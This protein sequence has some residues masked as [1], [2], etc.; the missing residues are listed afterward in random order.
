MVVVILVLF[1]SSVLQASTTP[2]YIVHPFPCH[3]GAPCLTLQD[4]ANDMAEYINSSA[5]FLFL[6]G[7]HYLNTELEL[8]F[9]KN[10]TFRGGGR[11]ATE[12]V[13]SPTAT[14]SVANSSNIII[15]S[16][17]II[18][19]GKDN[20]TLNSA[21]LSLQSTNFV[22]MHNIMFVQDN[23]DKGRSRALQFTNSSAE[24]INCSFANGHIKNG[25]AISAHSSHLTFSGK[26]L[27]QQ[28]TADF[29]G[30][31]IYANKTALIFNGDA[32]FSKNIA[33]SDYYP[34]NYNIGGGAIF[35]WQSTITF[36]GNSVFADNAPVHFFDYVLIGAAILAAEG[37]N[38]TI[39]G[40]STFYN[41]SGYTGGAIFLVNSECSILSPVSFRNN[42]ATM[43]SGGAIFVYASKLYFNNSTS[44]M[45]NQAKER[46]GGIYVENSIFR[47]NG[48]LFFI[49]NSVID[50]GGGAIYLYNSTVVLSGATTFAMNQGR[51][52]GAL[53]VNSNSRLVFKTGE[54]HFFDNKAEKG[55][56]IYFVDTSSTYA[57]QCQKITVE[58]IIC[59]FEISME[60]SHFENIQL[61]F[62]DNYADSGAAVYGGALDICKV[63]I[64]ENITNLRGYDVIS[65]I[66][67]FNHL[68]GES[69]Y[70]SSR[71]LKLCK[72]DK[73]ELLNCSSSNQ[74]LNVTVLPGRTFKLSVIPVGQFNMPSSSTVVTIFDASDGST[75]RTLSNNLTNTCRDVEYQLFTSLKYKSI[76]IY[77]KGCNSLNAS[78]MV[79]LNVGDCPP[80]FQLLDNTCKCEERLSNL[81][82]TD[83]ICD[84]ETGLIKRPGN[85][86][87]RPV[88]ENDTYE[89][90]QWSSGCQSV[91][92]KTSD[93]DNPIWLNFSNFVDEQCR[94]NHTGTLCGSCKASH[95]LVLS[96]MD[97]DLCDNKSLSLIL[98]FALA[99][100]ALIVVI[101]LL[102]LT[103]AKG[104]THG[105]ILYCNVVSICRDIIFPQ[106]EA[107]LSP[108]SIFIAWMN[109]DLGIPTCFFNGLD[110]Y[111]YA[112][113]QF[114]FPFYL[115]LLIALIIVTSK[116]S[117][118]IG[119]LFG[120]NPIAV[121]ATVILLSFTKLLQSSERSLSYDMLLNPDGT[122]TRVWRM[123]PSVDYLQGKHIILATFAILVIIILI[124]P[125]IFLL[126]FG[127]HLQKYSGR[128]GFRWFNNFKPLLDAYYAPYTKH[129]RYWT[130]FLLLLRS[131]LF[132][133]FTVTILNNTNATLVTAVSLFL[134]VVVIGWMTGRVYQTVY[135]E[136]LEASFILNICILAVA[137][138]HIRQVGKDQLIVSYT[139]VGIAFTQFVGIIIFHVIFRI[140]DHKFVV[141]IRSQLS[142]IY[143]KVFPP[144]KMKVPSK[145]ENSSLEDM[146]P[147]PIR[148]PLLEDAT[149]V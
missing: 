3:P 8:K 134:G 98:I 118:R 86:W 52:G 123:D 109:L 115:W 112:W 11:E 103:V 79:N 88:Y 9:V 1:F 43:R 37:S 72:C 2:E 113:L 111:S 131:T 69:S 127:F 57:T 19:Q 44:F 102:Q 47:N 132:L 67:E 84:I 59:P 34:T 104:T 124:V 125:Y 36:N 55:G 40:D 91:H 85:A 117:S 48:E 141:V 28:N 35:A 95:S 119:Q 60:N 89:G 126:L 51:Y 96:S 116:M 23:L 54:N 65:N 4:Y 46:G 82:G 62:T 33:G 148:E 77:P 15:N 92:C 17:K 7:S 140:K 78:L 143:K 39:N 128:K 74:I 16:I 63:R 53:E 135:L 93:T 80:G 108:L 97:C 107:Q 20:D 130:G 49:N 71:P 24:L 133:S 99:G 105:L 76:I 58:N 32:R 29:S 13:M 114:L 81:T 68:V 120:S 18:K 139:S 25:G 66:S 27:F 90:F 146:D 50:Y 94:S 138:Y 31:A 145:K 26:T 61:N 22:T 12:I 100:I 56:A 14:I 45:K 5:S 121:L 144:F 110:A 64:N 41:N 42:R 21:A 129:G 122:H 10:V 142:M 137:S 101:F 83:D 136:I 38:L 73:N 149:T 106:D 147:M 30:G 70:I 87:L 75:L 6:E